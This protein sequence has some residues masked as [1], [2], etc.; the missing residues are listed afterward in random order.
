MR[1]IILDQSFELGMHPE[2]S[3]AKNPKPLFEQAEEYTTKELEENKERIEMQN[4]TIQQGIPGGKPNEQELWVNQFN[5][6]FMKA[7]FSTSGSFSCENEKERMRKSSVPFG[8]NSPS[9]GVGAAA[10]LSSSNGFR[11]TWQSS[12]SPNYDVMKNNYFSIKDG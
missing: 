9:K 1:K 6:S 5:T 7:T 3:P 2:R 12:M 10:N 8:M 11:Q 4:F